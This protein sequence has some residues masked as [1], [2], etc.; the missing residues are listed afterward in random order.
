MADDLTAKFSV[1]ELI[2][3]RYR[4]KCLSPDDSRYYKESQ[5]LA[6]FFSLEA[7]LKAC[8]QVQKALLETRVEFSKADPKN[9]VELEEALSKF[10]P[11][12]A[13]LIEEKITK[14]DQLAVIE[15]LGR[16]VSL[17]TKAMLHPGTTSYDI[18][19]TA[20]SYLFKLAWKTTL[21]PK[22]LE[23]V[24]KLCDLAESYKFVGQVGRTHLQHTSPVLFGG[25]LAGYAARLAERVKK[26]DAAFEDLRGKISGIVG[27]GASIDIV[28]G[29]GKSLEFERR[30]L[31]KL[32]L[33]PDLT[34][35]QIVQ[36]ER[37]ADCGHAI[38]TLMGVL[39]DFA[40]DMRLLYSSEINEI[41]SFDEEKRLGGSSADAAKNNPIHW[42]NIAGTEPVVESGMRILYGLISTDFQRDLRGSKS[43]R[44]QPQ[45]M[46]AETYESLARAVKATNSLIVNN[47][48]MSEHLQKVRDFPSEAMVAVTRAHGWNHPQYGVGHEAVKEF[49][50]QAKGHR[51][52]LLETALRDPFFNDF[53]TKLPCREQR[54]LQGELGL[55]T[56]SAR[57]RLELNIQYA[58]KVINK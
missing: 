1:E 24:E 53:F 15:E 50:K 26:S 2:I 3:A 11:L 55:Y 44:Y 58:K 33:E 32:N 29:E 52:P 56:G 22:A 4:L 28:I 13:T 16:H 49:S 21:K 27:T 17:E 37:L 18:L 31:E 9:V 57:E 42:E 47:D 35:T 39:T 10:D 30:V 46:M 38:M 54:I 7:E 8:V 20:R 19:D 41:S 23:L 36:K 48:K 6:P 40:N 51:A 5:H 34:S 25:V 43:A 12:N 45:L 14:H